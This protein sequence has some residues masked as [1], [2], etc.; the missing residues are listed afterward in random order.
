M[1]ANLNAKCDATYLAGL[2]FLKLLLDSFDIEVADGTATF[3]EYAAS[4]MLVLAKRRL[5]EADQTPV[6]MLPREPH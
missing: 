4:Q 5:T 2:S 6:R 3:V 1:S